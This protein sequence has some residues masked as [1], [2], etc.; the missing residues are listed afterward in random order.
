M[1]YILFSRKGGEEK[2]FYSLSSTRLI[3]ATYNNAKIKV[4]EQM[5]SGSKH[6]PRAE[7]L[8]ESISCPL[9]RLALSS[10]AAFQ[11]SKLGASLG[12]AVATDGFSD[13]LND[14]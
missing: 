7:K 6:F 12:C 4:A 1:K 9:D 13:G 8:D 3:S 14:G 5:H 10:L 2:I 11:G